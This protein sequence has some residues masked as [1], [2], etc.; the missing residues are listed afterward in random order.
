MVIVSC[1]L[2]TKETITTDSA[3]RMNEIEYRLTLPMNMGVM[4]ASV[5]PDCK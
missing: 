1:V 2:V 3:W 4:R 5:K